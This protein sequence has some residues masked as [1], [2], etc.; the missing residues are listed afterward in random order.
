MR[1]LR[2]PH[3][4]LRRATFFFNPLWLCSVILIDLSLKF[5]LLSFVATLYVSV[6]FLQNLPIFLLILWDKLSD[7]SPADA[8]SM[9]IESSKVVESLL[10]KNKEVLSRMHAMIFPKASQEKTLEQLMDAFAVD[11]KDNIEVLKRTSHTYGALLAFQL[12]MGYGFKA[13]IEQVTK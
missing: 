10:W 8:L 11:T 4:K 9:T 3:P 7:I 6:Y 12:M 1:K 2:G 5:T 13:D